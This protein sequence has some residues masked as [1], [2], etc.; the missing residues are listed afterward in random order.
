MDE[1]Q[2]TLLSALEKAKEQQKF[3]EEINDILEVRYKEILEKNGDDQEKWPKE[4]LIE[5]SIVIFA[6]ITL[7]AKRTELNALIDAG[8]HAVDVLY[9]EKDESK[10]N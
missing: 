9:P 1:Q 5:I 7:D 2:I 4:A 10:I 8:K 6:G 3:Y